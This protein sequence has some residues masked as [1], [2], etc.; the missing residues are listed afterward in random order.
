MKKFYESPK[1]LTVVIGLHG[2]LLGDAMS[3]DEPGIT[4]GEAREQK[5]NW[6]DDWDDTDN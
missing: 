3:Q 6:N 4:P 5:N 2:R 1:S